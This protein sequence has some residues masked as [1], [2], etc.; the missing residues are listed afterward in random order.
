MLYYQTNPGQ[1]GLCRIAEFIWKD[2]AIGDGEAA[3]EA[4]NGSKQGAESA[5]ERRD[6][7]TR[8]LHASA[9]Q[10]E[11][12]SGGEEMAVVGPDLMEPGLHSGYYVDGVPGAKRR[13]S[14]EASGEEL[15]L[16]ENVIRYRNQA[17]SFVREVV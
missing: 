6:Q 3:R 5:E 8:L 4:I 11:V 10:S 15:D 9:L 16:A 12:R 2:S 7:P 1:T 13:R 17:P 14:G